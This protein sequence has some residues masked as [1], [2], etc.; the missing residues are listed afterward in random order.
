MS[1]ITNDDLTRSGTGCF[2]D[3]PYGTWASKGLIELEFYTKSQQRTNSIG[4]CPI[5]G[6][7]YMGRVSYR[8]CEIDA[9]GV[10]TLLELSSSCRPCFDGLFV[11]AVY[12]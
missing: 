9:P 2:I 6:Q 1:K 10:N 3:R 4:R 8:V 7:V 11:L 12:N 5:M